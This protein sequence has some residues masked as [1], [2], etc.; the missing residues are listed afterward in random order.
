MTTYSIALRLRRVTY[1]D[2]YIAVPVTDAIV[3]PN[4]DGSMRIA[5]EA[6]IAEGIRIGQDSRVEWQ[7]ESTNIEAH[8]IQQAAPEDRNTLDAYHDQSE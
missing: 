2:A 5:P 7:A 4:P 8:P 1:E 3:K 6:L